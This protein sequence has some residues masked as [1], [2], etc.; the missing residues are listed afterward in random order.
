MS[1]ESI[2]TVVVDRCGHCNGLWF[3]AAELDRAIL[4][5]LPPGAEP[6]EDRIPERGRSTRRCPRCTDWLRTAG[7]S[8]LVLDRCPQCRGLFVEA[9][10][11]AYFNRQEAPYDATSFEAA[12]RDAAIAGG[13]ALLT[14]NGL[15][16]II[17]R[18]WR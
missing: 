7:W 11:W 13:S 3:D 12:F 6:P 16:W 10:E 9:H 1:V 18:L 2:D 14:A 5:I 4:Q 17:L 8:G 15:I